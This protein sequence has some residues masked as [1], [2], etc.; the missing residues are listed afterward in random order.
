MTRRLANPKSITIA[1]VTWTG[2]Q[3]HQAPLLLELPEPGRR[4]GFA[5]FCILEFCRGARLL[6]S[7]FPEVPA[8]RVCRVPR[9]WMVDDNVRSVKQWQSDMPVEDTNTSNDIKIS[10]YHA[11]NAVAQLRD[12]KKFAAIGFDA[13]GKSQTQGGR[14]RSEDDMWSL[15]SRAQSMFKFVR[16]ELAQCVPI[17]CSQ[18]RLS[19]F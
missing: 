3:F 17:F 5:R 11:M 1:G 4:V 18:T 8:N 7:I 12:A 10:F 19:R 13:S 15:D 9:L 14:A 6:S 2:S 16:L